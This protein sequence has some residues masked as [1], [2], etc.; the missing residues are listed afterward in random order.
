MHPCEMKISFYICS[1]ILLEGRKC[2]KR[3]ELQ[4]LDF[5]TIFEI[6]FQRSFETYKTLL[7]L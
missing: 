4:M 6:Y 5:G 2:Q 3:R 1:V 7:R